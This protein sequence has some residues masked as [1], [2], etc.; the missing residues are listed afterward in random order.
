MSRTES[1]LITFL[2]GPWG[3]HRFIVG[4]IGTGLIWLFTFG[5]FGIGWLVDLIKVCTNQF[6][7]K[8]GRV[9]GD[10]E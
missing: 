10:S 8:D 2:L 1:V 6:T 5:C 7:D 3:V 4:K 9:W